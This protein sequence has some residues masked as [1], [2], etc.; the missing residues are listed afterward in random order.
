MALIIWKNFSAGEISPQLSE[1]TDIDLYYRAGKKIENFVPLKFGGIK[2]RDGLK[3]MGVINES[4]YDP[5]VK[6][7][8][9]KYSESVSYILEFTHNYFRI[10]TPT[11]Y[12]LD[13][14]N[15][16]LKVYSGILVDYIN[17]FSYA[18][19]EN[20]LYI[21]HSRFAPRIIELNGTTWTSY[22]MK[23]NS[24]CM[25]PTEVRVT[26]PRPT[27]K[28][29]PE[30]TIYKKVSYTVIP[31]D[32][33]DIPGAKSYTL[34]SMNVP[35]YPTPDYYTSIIWN[36]LTY[37][38]GYLLY[39]VE[40][41]IESLL[42]KTTNNSYKDF[43]YH[44]LNHNKGFPQSLGLFTAHDQYPSKVTFYDRRLIFAASNKEQHTIWGSV[45]ALFHNFIAESIPTDAC[46]WKFTIASN[47]KNPI[48]W[49]F[50]SDKLIIG[51]DADEWRI[52]G[53]S[54]ESIT[55]NSVE[56]RRLSSWGSAEMTPKALGDDILFIDNTRKNIRAMNKNNNFS[57]SNLNIYA[58]HL[59]KDCKIINWDISTGDN[60]IIY[61]VLDNGS[62]IGLTY[63]KDHQVFAWHRYITDGKFLDICTLKNNGECN[64]FVAIER[65]VNGTKIKS[66]EMFDK[67]H[68]LDSFISYEGAET[69]NLEGLEHLKGKIV[70]VSTNTKSSKKYTVDS[71]GKITLDEPANSIV[72]GL[73]FESTLETLP[74]ESATAVESL[75]ARKNKITSIKLRLLDTLG[76]EVG[77]HNDELMELQYDNVEENNMNNNN[78]LDLYSGTKYVGNISGYDENCSIIIKQN[79]SLPATVLSIYAEVLGITL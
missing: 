58:D 72:V 31:Y 38:K 22:D 34:A 74:L 32:E 60:Q 23:F 45:P 44:E 75:K 29:I 66:L 43:G 39:E 40:D 67:T 42:L 25:T 19:Y 55:P 65:E 52:S 48:N 21:C 8:Q 20:K 36:M 41:G 62:M 78:D 7:I 56:V 1:R 64:L 68:Y 24:K 35:K 37:A 26:T 28:P 46:P 59:T 79:N 5:G 12:L 11:G 2:R 14:Y 17:D 27:G 71:N 76:L 73:N 30:G 47:Q 13:S 63:D 10:I 15:S 61:L 4:I 16:V 54:G 50:S 69:T 3:F 77:I 6:F 9:F 70:E 51:S 49:L 33:D 53:N 57:I 18:Q